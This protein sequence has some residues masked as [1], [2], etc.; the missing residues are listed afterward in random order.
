MMALSGYLG[1]WL[2]RRA[3][4]LSGQTFGPNEDQVLRSDT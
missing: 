3:S 2:E 1:S 4:R